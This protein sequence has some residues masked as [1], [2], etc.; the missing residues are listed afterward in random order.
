M[1]FLCLQNWIHYL[2][3]FIILALP[4]LLL[5]SDVNLLWCLLSYTINEPSFYL[6][7]MFTV[8]PHHTH[9]IGTLSS[10]AHIVGNLS[11]AGIFTVKRFICTCPV[12]Q[13]I[14][15]QPAKEMHIPFHRNRC[16]SLLPSHPAG[17]VFFRYLELPPKFGLNDTSW[18][19]FWWTGS[20]IKHLNRHM[21][22][23]TFIDRWQIIL[24]MILFRHNYTVPLPKLYLQLHLVLY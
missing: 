12:T 4:R 11:Y 7:K 5:L 15:Y 18:Y 23:S 9:I 10:F 3:Y 22:L 6:N 19:E 20:W 2:S 1:Q 16:T 8:R 13:I 21:H 24:Q 17:T 14:L